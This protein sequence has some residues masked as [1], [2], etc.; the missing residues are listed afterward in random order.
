MLRNVSRRV[1]MLA[2]AGIL[3][4]EAAGLGPWWTAPF[5]V[6]QPPL[7]VKLSSADLVPVECRIL[8]LCK[9]SAVAPKQTLKSLNLSCTTKVCAS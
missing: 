3:L 4:T 7:S 5:R 6:S 8:L 9:E 2:V 1:A